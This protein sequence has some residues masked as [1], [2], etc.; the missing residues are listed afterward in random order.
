MRFAALV[1]GLVGL[2]WACPAAAQTRCAQFEMVGTGAR[3]PYNPF[4]P[5]DASQA[6]QVRVGRLNSAAS[7]VRFLLVDTT[8]GSTGPKLGPNG[9]MD[10]DIRWTGDATRTVFVADNQLVNETNGALG[11]FNSAGVDMVDFRL[12]IPRGQSAPASI[13]LEEL[14]VRY[15]CLDASGNT[16]G[17][18]QEQLAPIEIRAIVPLF[19]AAYIGGPG[20]Y[21]GLID[22]GEINAA[23]ANLTK[24][25]SVTAL[26]TVPYEVLVQSDHAG[27]IIRTATDPG[28]PYRMRFAQTEVPNG[29]RIVCP[30]T[31]MPGG[32]SRDFEVTLDRNAL[33]GAASGDYGDVVTLTFTPKDIASPAGCALKP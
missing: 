23:T 28:I 18:Q 27:K 14:E 10:Y 8:R 32:Q 29:G 3:L 9:P 7:K 24:S 19:A 33:K 2:L 30:V 26:S 31:P 12:T 22:F 17:T 6:F 5:N 21:R 16:I 1:A 20:N 25:L 11:N 15:Q 13:H 4:D